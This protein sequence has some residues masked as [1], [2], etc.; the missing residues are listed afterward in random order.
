MARDSDVFLDREAELA[1]LEQRYR[2]AGAELYVLYGRRRVGKTEL[3]REFCQGKRYVFF[4]ADLGTEASA[5]A[6]FSRRVSEFAFGDPEVLPPFGS[7][8]AAFGFVARHAAE[9]RLVVVLDEFTYLIRANAAVPSILQRL[10]DT[11]LRQTRL[12]LVLCGSYV[13]L[14]EKHV[15]AYDAPLYG[16]RTGQWQLQPLAF[17]DAIRLLPRYGPEDHVRAYGILGGVPLYLRQFDDG[18]ALLDNVE[19]R[20]LSLGTFLY[21]EPR[22]LLLQELGEPHRH[23]SILE[24]IAAGRTRQNEIAQAAGIVPTSLPFYLDTLRALGLVEREVPATE[25]QPH[26]SKRGMY[27]ILDPFF[28]F[29]FRFVYPNRSLIDRGVTGPVRQQVGAQ[30]NHFLGPVFEDVCRDHVWRL[31]AADHLGFAA[32]AVGR[33]WDDRT[34]I[35]VLALGDSIALVGECKWSERPVGTNVLDDLVAKAAAFR[36]HGGGRT[37]RYALFARAGFTPD[38]VRRADV[39]GVLL[40]RLEDL[41]TATGGGS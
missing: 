40:V 17:G 16:R 13:G 31:A 15:L 28:R 32:R 36:P 12:M 19:Q 11:A 29:W 18:A 35:D 14:M 22:F 10:W 34:E 25:T 24:A 9:E 30:L 3:L 20:V 38:L 1:A 27:R 8:D 4:V 26:K 39:D 37:L 33:W 6:E 2:S 7:W 21:D 23:F 5:L 41:V